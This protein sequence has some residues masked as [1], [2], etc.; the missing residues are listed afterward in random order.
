MPGFRRDQ[1]RSF[2]PCGRDDV[3]HQQLHEEHV[4]R[5]QGKQ[6]DLGPPAIA[7]EAVLPCQ[8]IQAGP[9][10]RPVLAASL[11]EE[12]R[13]LFQRG[14]RRTRRIAG[15]SPPPG[16]G[17]LECQAGLAAEVADDSLGDR[18]AQAGMDH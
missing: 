9:G 16:T 15:E 12:G 8:P 2:A 11:A 5:L 18:R 4:P 6:D 1:G 14:L 13:P 17:A 10:P 7:G 3:A